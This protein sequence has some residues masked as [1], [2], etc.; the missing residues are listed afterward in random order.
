MIPVHSETASLLSKSGYNSLN[1]T[2]DQP[3]LSF[4]KIL[5]QQSPNSGLSKVV[6]QDIYVFHGTI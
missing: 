3:P 4:Q 2:T 6:L 1:P 5:T